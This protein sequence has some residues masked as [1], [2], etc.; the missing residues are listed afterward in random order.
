LAA[1]ISPVLVAHSVSDLGSFN[2]S[3]NPNQLNRGLNQNQL[4]SNTNHIS[5]FSP[6]LLNVFNPKHLIA[7][8]TT[9]L[10]SMI[11]LPGYYQ[12]TS[13]PGTV[14]PELTATSE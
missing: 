9:S 8:S 5:T 14:K 12:F 2:R 6:K 11:S 10:A 13:L 3:L 4:S 7:T 1:A